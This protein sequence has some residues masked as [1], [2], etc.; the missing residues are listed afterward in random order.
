M[1]GLRLT[2]A[3]ARHL[4]LAALGLAGA[5]DPT[6]DV[7][8]SIAA[9]GVLQIDT[10]NVVARSPSL[11]LWSRA[12]AGAAARLDAALAE[13]AIA[14]AWAHE[15][16]FVA[17][18]DYP[19]HRRLTLARFRR[20]ART[21]ADWIAAHPGPVAEVLARLQTDGAVRA[22]DFARERRTRGWWD[23][24]EH[25]LA[26]EMLFARGDLLVARR[27]GFQRVYDLHQRVRPDWDDALAPVLDTALDTLVERTVGILGVAAPAWIADYF[28]LPQREAVARA[29]RLAATGRLLSVHIE[30]IGPAYLHPARHA[31]AQ[32]AADGS[33][34]PR[35]AALL[36]PFDPLIWDRRRLAQLFDFDYR[37]ECY[38]PAERRRYG[39]FAL[40]I[41]HAGRIVGRTD[42][43]ADRR[44]G[45]LLVRTLHL[46]PDVPDD[47]PLATALAS[48]LA[49]LA[50]W[51]NTP[52]IVVAATVAAPRLAEALRHA[53]PSIRPQQHTAPH[54]NAVPH[55]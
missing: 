29:A 51:Q 25:K 19:L 48:A 1:A 35:P 36:S 16:S 43:K 14:E 32:A 6:T 3:A 20:V 31:L 37:I 42:L 23:W 52:E 8:A 26:L 27:D 11:V 45:Q 2:R 24:S 34:M 39:Y 49:D 50:C 18:D 13:G 28:R 41:L 44:A 22:R 53:V 5:P 38:T 30:D 54:G 15:A 10:I 40:P 17:R 46:E 21:A 9:M 47:E 33:I 12:G 4:Q 7:A 55:R